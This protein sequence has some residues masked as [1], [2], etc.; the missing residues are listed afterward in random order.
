MGELKADGNAHEHTESGLLRD[1]NIHRA[2]PLLHVL[3]A[4]HPLYLSLMRAAEPAA[5][6]QRLPENSLQSRCRV[7]H[8]FLGVIQPLG[9]AQGLDRGIH[10]GGR[11]G[12]RLGANGG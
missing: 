11:I 6:V 2:H 3:F 10:L 4:G 9:I 1:E 7:G 8:H 12:V 5:F